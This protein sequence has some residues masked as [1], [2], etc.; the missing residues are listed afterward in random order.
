MTQA[1]RILA[2]DLR[3]GSSILAYFSNPEGEG[4]RLVTIVDMYVDHKGDNLPRMQI[5]NPVHA[6]K[7]SDHISVILTDDDGNDWREPLDHILDTDL[8]RAL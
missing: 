8:Y 2:E 5:R 1:K 6:R 3:V 7:H 4:W